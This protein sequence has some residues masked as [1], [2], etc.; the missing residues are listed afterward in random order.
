MADVVGR[1][2]EG[3]ADIVV[4]DDA[5]L[6]AQAGLLGVADRGRHAAVGHRH[7]EVG[8]ARRSR[9]RARRRSACGPRRRPC[10]R[11][12]CRAGRSRHTRRCRS[13]AAR[14]RTG[15]GCARPSRSMTTISPGSTSRTNS[16]PRMSSA[17]VSEARIQAPSSRPSTSGRTPRG[18]RPPR[19]PS[20]NSPTSDQAPSTSRSASTR[21]S[22]MLWRWL[23]AI[24][25]MIT[26]V[27]LVDWNSEPSSTSRRRRSMALVRLPL[28]ADRE[29]R[30]RRSRRTA[31]ARC[32]ACWRRWWSSGRGPIAAWPGSPSMTARR[33][34]VSPISPTARWLWNMGAVEADDPGRLLAAMLQRVQAERRMRRGSACPKRRRC[35]I[36]PWACR[37]RRTSRDRHRA[38]RSDLKVAAR[39]ASPAPAAASS[40]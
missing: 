31:A 9:A 5:E 32:A 12:R 30:R 24:R 23:R 39:P 8:R 38:R 7:D 21:R 25:W 17:Q 1:L 4:A 14:G 11:P 3:A 36:P 33:L 2:D 20:S 26:S 27:S 18:S 34:K 13:A 28:C 15:A 10:P 19:M 16:A 29:A 22:T 37:R 35:R 6:E 40:V